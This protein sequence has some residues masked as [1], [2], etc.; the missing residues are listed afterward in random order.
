[1]SESADENELGVRITLDGIECRIGQDENGFWDVFI[2]HSGGG[3]PFGVPEITTTFHE[4]LVRGVVDH[5]EAIAQAIH[6]IALKKQ[7]YTILHHNPEGRVMM[8]K[9][10]KFPPPEEWPSQWREQE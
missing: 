3:A 10:P 7:G 1:M 9:L 6:L 5:T 8:I 4:W 2:E